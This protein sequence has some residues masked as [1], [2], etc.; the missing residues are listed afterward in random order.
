MSAQEL[1]DR[2]VELDLEIKQKTKELTEIKNSLKVIAENTG[3]KILKG[4]HGKANI[5][6][7]TSS[8][9]AALEFITTCEE[10]GISKE[11]IASALKVLIAQAKKILGEEQYLPIITTNSN[12]YGV[13]KFTKL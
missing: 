9:I 7:Q 1:V 8:Q 11:G 3:V 12:P 5:S 10:V 13:I 6:A 2:G 4:K